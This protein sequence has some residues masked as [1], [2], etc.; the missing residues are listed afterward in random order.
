M[1]A[2]TKPHR[3]RPD[4]RTAMRRL[5]G[6]VRAAIPFGAHAL[7]EC[8]GECDRCPAKLL[9]LLELEL[10]AW[11]RGLDEGALPDLADLSRLL[12]VSRE[13][14]QALGRRDTA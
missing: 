7:R 2:A 1:S 9:E 11:E 13:V 6:E 5:I 4:T 10:E 14:E 8:T 3:N 12:R